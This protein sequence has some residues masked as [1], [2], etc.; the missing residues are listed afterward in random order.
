MYE[1]EYHRFSDGT[2]DPIA[3]VTRDHYPPE[4]G[5]FSISTCTELFP[6]F[7][8][9]SETKALPVRTS[10][11]KRAQC[12]FVQVLPS[13]AGTTSA[14]RIPV[15][16]QCYAFRIWAHVSWP[17]RPAGRGHGRL[18]CG[19]PTAGADPRPAHVSVTQICA[20]T[21]DTKEACLRYLAFILRCCLP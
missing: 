2:S 12:I 13:P 4:I 16:G 8:A 3:C 9:P 21:A 10:L 19:H 6:Y 17:H 14:F 15:G 7:S 18:G 1:E 11:R 5:A 20:R